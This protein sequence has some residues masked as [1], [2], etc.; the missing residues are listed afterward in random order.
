MLANLLSITGRPMTFEEEGKLNTEFN[1]NHVRL[2]MG[3]NFHCTKP[4]W[5]RMIFA[6]PKEKLVEGLQRVE[7]VLGLKGWP[8]KKY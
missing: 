6:V 2:N 7:Q 8:P 1:G 4:G 3:K 5:F